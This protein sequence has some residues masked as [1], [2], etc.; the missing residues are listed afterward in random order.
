MRKN[1]LATS[2]FAE[3]M[4]ND[5]NHYVTRDRLNNAS[6][7]QRSDAIAK[8]IFQRQ[9]PLEL[10]FEDISNF[11]VQNTVVGLLLQEPD[12]KKKDLASEVIKKAPRPSIDLDIQKRLEALKTTTSLTIAITMG[13][14][15]LQHLHQHLITLFCRQPHHRHCHLIHFKQTFHRL[16]RRYLHR[17]CQSKNREPDQRLPR[18][19]R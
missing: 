4:Q 2:D 16:H 15:Y 6:F 10:V 14:L 9:N 12:I 17:H 19:R 8:N 18:T 13:H 5:I 3:G 11:Y 7:R 1:L